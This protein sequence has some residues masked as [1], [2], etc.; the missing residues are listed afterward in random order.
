MPGRPLLPTP[1]PKALVA[2]IIARRT[3]IMTSIAVGTVCIEHERFVKDRDYV[4]ARSSREPRR[5]LQ[6]ADTGRPE[7]GLRACQQGE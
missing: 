5:F 3:D 6:F 2:Q 7:V 4:L 1:E